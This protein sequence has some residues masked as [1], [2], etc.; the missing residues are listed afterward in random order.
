VVITDIGFAVALDPTL[1]RGD[2]TI[3][4][5]NLSDVKGTFLAA[6][7]SPDAPYVLT[8]EDAG[9]TL[10]PLA[11]RRLTST[12]LAF[13]GEAGLQLPAVGR[14]PFGNAYLLYAYPDYFAF[15]GSVRV[16]VP[17]MSIEGGI[18]GEAS[19]A[20]KRFS[21]EGHVEACV[22]GLKLVLHGSGP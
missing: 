14:I 16:V 10:A 12:S 22:A 9:T 5:A 15:G 20:T 18:A 13:G 7:A 21:L 2:G 6:F 8:A 17:G 4:V 1:L 3:S 19:L 11:R